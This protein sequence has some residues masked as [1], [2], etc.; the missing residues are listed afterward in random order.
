MGIMNKIKTWWASATPVERVMT[1]LGVTGTAT[2]LIVCANCVSTMDKIHRETLEKVDKGLDSLS[3]NVALFPKD[4]AASYEKLKGIYDKT[5]AVS[6][7][8]LFEGNWD[9]KTRLI[10]MP[11]EQWEDLRQDILDMIWDQARELDKVD[12]CNETVPTQVHD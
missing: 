12:D 3:V 2:S 8:D 5:E 10:A 11:E 1:V 4:C 7:Q 9:P 6:E